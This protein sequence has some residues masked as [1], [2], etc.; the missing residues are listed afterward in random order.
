MLIGG[1]A[2]QG[3]KSLSKNPQENSIR[4]FILIQLEMN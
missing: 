1:E 2:D 3:L 4:I